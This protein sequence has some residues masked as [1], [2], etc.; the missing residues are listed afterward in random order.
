MSN[1]KII[2]LCQYFYPEYISSAELP[3][4]T[5]TDLSKNDIDVK[6]LCGYPYEYLNANKEIKTKEKLNENFYINRIKYSKFK[7]SFFL[8]RLLNYFSFTFFSLMNIRSFKD[9]DICIVYSNP[10]IV[11][12]VPFLAKKVY[13][14][15][16]IFVSYDVYPEI[17]VTT[18]TLSKDSIIFKLMTLINKVVFP[19]FDKII[20]L[21]SEMK[22]FLMHSRNIPPEKIEIISNWEDETKWNR[23]PDEF[24]GNPKKDFIISYFG[25]MGIA[26]DMETIKKAIS[27]L[28]HKKNIKFMLVGHGNKKED[29]RE[30]FHR[31]NIFNVSVL[32]FLHNQELETKMSES[33]VFLVSLEKDIKGLAVPSKTYS[34]LAM[35]KPVIAIMH[36]E[37]EIAL[38]LEKSKSGFSVTNFDVDTLTR[39]IELLEADK[40]L[41]SR[42]AHN[43]YSLYKRK[44]T[45][46]IG[47]NKY[48]KII[49]E[50]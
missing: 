41:Y 7:K 19:E 39:Y 25:N 40:D 8:G 49:E 14:T 29:L 45:R 22:D 20:A 23:P 12:I 30:Y 9:R 16:I 37:M 34:Y 6:V 44:Y 4:Q 13:G 27:A 48:K 43:S 31:N 3:Y 26:Q 47:T 38:E 33:D 28:S 17:A 10:P 21:S 1:K 42:M 15:K 35:G 18:N 11:T 5:A 46:N 50:L 2:I 36:P 32:D 24:Y